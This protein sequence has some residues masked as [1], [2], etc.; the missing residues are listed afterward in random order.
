MEVQ[1][2]VET[3]PAHL[4]KAISVSILQTLKN[5]TPS[6]GALGTAF[7]SRLALV[8]QQEQRRGGCG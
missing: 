5:Q 3:A 8:E 2:K 7:V 6:R 1:E 4:K